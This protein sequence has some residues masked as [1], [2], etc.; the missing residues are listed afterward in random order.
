MC[1]KPFEE[2]NIELQEDLASKNFIS[3]IQANLSKIESVRNINKWKNLTLPDTSSCLHRP[4]LH[5]GQ[6]FTEI[7]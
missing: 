7:C 3:T 2:K 6:A 4:L 1:T 5:P